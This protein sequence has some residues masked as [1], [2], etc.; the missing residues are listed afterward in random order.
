MKIFFL[1]NSKLKIII[2]NFNHNTAKIQLKYSI[3]FHFYF[4]IAML[5]LNMDNEQ[6]PM[7]KDYKEISEITPGQMYQDHETKKYI[8]R[9]YFANI[10]LQRIF[11]SKEILLI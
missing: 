8:S 4:G 3:T 6:V 9:I 5:T 2:L 11:T 1:L 7:D 10:I